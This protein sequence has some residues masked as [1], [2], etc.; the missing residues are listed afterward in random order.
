MTPLGWGRCDL[1]AELPQ[2]LKILWV[3]L[4]CFPGVLNGLFRFTKM[5]RDFDQCR[6]GLG[7]FRVC[8]RGFLKSLHRFAI[9]LALLEQPAGGGAGHPSEWGAG[10]GK[11]LVGEWNR[12]EFDGDMANQHR[13][14]S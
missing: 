4:D 1:D 13:S 11:H 12:E 5:Q 2:Q 10:H 6:V 3:D 8:V 14:E 9:L 7:E